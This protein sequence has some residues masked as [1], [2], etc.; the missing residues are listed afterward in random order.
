MVGIEENAQTKQPPMSQHPTCIDCGEKAP[1]TNTNYT[2]I[3]TSFSWR[4]TRR[5]L[6]DGTASL[7]W[8][9]AACWRKHKTAM[10]STAPD[11]MSGG[12]APDSVKRRPKG[13]TPPS[14]PG[15]KRSV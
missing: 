1:E 8:R 13:S 7:E 9:C 11:A 4:L 10:R 15:G 14:P 2:L 5:T 3:S 6:A 12:E